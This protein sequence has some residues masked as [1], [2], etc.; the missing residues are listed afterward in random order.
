MAHRHE[1]HRD[2]YQ[3][4]LGSMNPI[5]QE[6]S[7]EAERTGQRPRT[8]PDGD[9]CRFFIPHH[10]D[11]DIYT[12]AVIQIKRV[13]TDEVLGGIDRCRLQFIQSPTLSSM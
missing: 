6:M 3:E 12:Q 11:E 2:E 13:P 9:V 10:T 4:Q 5:W 7:D 8:N 1:Q